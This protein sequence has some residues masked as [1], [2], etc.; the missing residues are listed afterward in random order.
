MKLLDPHAARRRFVTVTFLFWLPVG[1]YI[2]SQ[3]LLLTE[4]GMSLAVVAGLFAVHSLTVSLMELPTG[5]LSDVLG[6]RSVLAAAGLLNLCALTLMAL[7]TTV[8][9]LAVAMFLMGSGRALSSGPAEAWYVDTVQAHSGA[10]AELRTG[11][12]RGNTASAAA[13]AAGT[14]LGGA[15][16]LLL[17]LGPDP[18]ARLAGATGGLVLPLS[19]PGLLGAAVGVGFVAYVLT[20]LPEPP[21]PP[22][23]LR[24]VLRGVPATML[25]GLRLGVTESLVRRVL[26]T[27]AAAG[28][29]LAAV[30]LLT[31]GRAARLTGAPESGAVLYAA[32]ACAGFLCTAVGSHCA[33]L[34]ARLTGSS[35][36]AVL[37]ALGVS[38]TGLALL[39][40]TAAWDG[41]PAPLA[42]AA[43]GYALVYLGLGAAGPNENDLLHRRVDSTV[44]ATALSVKSLALQ[45]VA[46]LTGL[47]AGSLPVGPLPWLVG[48]TALLLG[49]LLWTRRAK[50]ATAA[51]P[52]PVLP[53]EEVVLT[54]SG[55]GPVPC[56][57]SRVAAP[58]AR[59]SG[60]IQPASSPPEQQCGCR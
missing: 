4:R 57:G 13:L 44:R 55:S 34:T 53:S 58:R 52:S 29:A 46:A 22:A 5:G 16:P 14:L 50:P 21:R 25:G 33:P 32:L 54:A 28:A 8:W 6:R 15:L 51:H 36:H 10:G 41:G 56:C 47:V 7:G 2:P 59:H 45:S 27:A 3:V 9:A 23:T 26:L 17:G 40:V 48:A 42:L 19:V 39:G 20:A 35:E 43:L 24:G 37:A 38:T 30:E 18:G 11:L 12:S 60:G 1:L 49:A 31:P